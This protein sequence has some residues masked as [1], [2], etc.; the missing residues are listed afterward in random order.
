MLWKEGDRFAAY[1]GKVCDDG[2]CAAHWFQATTGFAA[3][4]YDLADNVD[5]VV[6]PDDARRSPGGSLGLLLF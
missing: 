2:Q 5:V 3:E 1:A 6:D 4:G